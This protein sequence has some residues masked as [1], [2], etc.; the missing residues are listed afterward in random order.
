M[1]QTIVIFGASGD[2][3]SRKLVPALYE[4][5]RKGR[6]P[7]GTRIVGFS[8]TPFSDDSWRENLRGSTAQYVGETF[9]TAAWKT[10]AASISLRAG[11]HRQGGRLCR[12]GPATE[13]VGRRRRRHAGLLPGHGA[14]ALRAG[15][16]PSRR[17]RPGRPGPRPPPHRHR[18]A[19]RHQPGDGPATERRRPQGLRRKPGLSHRPLPGQGNRAERAGVPLRQQHLR[20]GLEPQLHRS[21][22]DHRRRGG[23][24]RPSRAPITTAWACCATCSRTTSCNSSRSRPWNRPPASR[25]IPSATRRSR[26][27]G[28]SGR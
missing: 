11:R 9:D 24:H 15:H 16:R 21:R 5:F 23:D 17:R 7:E 13:R 19:L 20:A 4:V 26:C 18:K 12:L 28:R 8:R 6:L 10:L 27:C 22:A 3:T 2:L 25:P 1:A 14:A